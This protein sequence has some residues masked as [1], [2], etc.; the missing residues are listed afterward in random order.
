M[1]PIRFSLSK[2][3][4]QGPQTRILFGARGKAASTISLGLKLLLHLVHKSTDFKRL[5]R[6]NP[7]AQGDA[8]QAEQVM[9]SAA[10][11][12]MAPAPSSG[13][14]HEEGFHCV[15]TYSPARQ[16][17]SVSLH[18]VG[19]SGR[20]LFLVLICML[21][22]L[23]RPFSCMLPRTLPCMFWLQGRRQ[24]GVSGREGRISPQL[25]QGHGNGRE[26][27]EPIVLAHLKIIH[28]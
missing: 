26:A 19:E 10:V 24:E 2:L 7:G 14:T 16:P 18:F 23:E 13:T 11:T 8:S 6:V 22:L 3:V 28:L 27:C 12:A 25:N 15:I 4:I 5:E 17:L 20:N 1:L 21:A 9:L